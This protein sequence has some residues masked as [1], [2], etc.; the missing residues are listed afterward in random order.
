MNDIVLVS[1]DMPVQVLS[2]GKS[3]PGMIA[4]KR[5]P[6]VLAVDQ[7]LNGGI[8]PAKSLRILSDKI[9]LTD[10][11]KELPSDWSWREAYALP[12]LVNEQM[13]NIILVPFSEAGQKGGE[14]ATWIG[15]K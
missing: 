6:Q 13:K 2:G 3:Y 7:F 11:R 1:F 8:D 12:M 5:G 10:A 4:L 15:S 9:V 14:I